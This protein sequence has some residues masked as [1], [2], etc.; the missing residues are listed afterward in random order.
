[1]LNNHNL[2]QAQESK[3]QG[4]SGLSVEQLAREQAL[5]ITWKKMENTLF[6][7]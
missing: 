7:Q 4:S 5:A 2:H 6:P 3:K 1:M